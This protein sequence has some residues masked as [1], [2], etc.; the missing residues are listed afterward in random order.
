MRSEE[1]RGSF[2]SKHF[3]SFASIYYFFFKAKRIKKKEKI[4]KNNF[5]NCRPQVPTLL[6]THS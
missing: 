4:I 3:N 1:C 2:A 5:Y 6:T